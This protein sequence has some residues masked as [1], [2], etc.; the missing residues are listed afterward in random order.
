MELWHKWCGSL[1]P[2]VWH[3][4]LG[5]FGQCFQIT[6]FESGA[7]TLPY[8]ILI[9]LG[10]WCNRMHTRGCDSKTRTTEIVCCCIL[11]LHSG[12][13]LFASN[14][15]GQYTMPCVAMVCS[16]YYCV[17][18]LTGAF[19]TWWFPRLWRHLRWLCL[20]VFVAYT[21]LLPSKIQYWLAI[22][23][24][25]PTQLPVL[26]LVSFAAVYL[27]LGILVID[28]ILEV[29]LQRALADP[30]PDPDGVAAAH[31][32]VHGAAASDATDAA[33]SSARAS[34]NLEDTCNLF[35][36]VLFL[37]IW[38]LLQWGH[39]RGRL[40]FEDL[41]KIS[42]L[43]NP[44]FISHQFA[45]AWNQAVNR[46]PSQR[47]SLL[48]VLY[49]LYW[50]SFWL[51]G[52]LMFISSAALVC[53]PIFVRLLLEYADSGSEDGPLYGYT[54]AFGLAAVS[55]LKQ[56]TE[57]QFWYVGVRCTVHVQTA[58]MSYTYYKT[59]NLSAASRKKY[60]PG[61]LSNLMT[62]DAQRV[63]TTYAVPYFH[64][65]GW[66]ALGV[67]GFALY[68]L[69]KM[70]GSAS[71][72]GFGVMVLCLAVGALAA[73]RSL[74]YARTVQSQR[75]ARGAFLFRVLSNIKSIK[76]DLL[77]RQ[78]IAAVDAL[79]GTETYALLQKLGLWGL[80]GC[81]TD[82]SLILAP[83]SCLTA[84]CFL[85]HQHLTTSTVFTALT[86]FN[87]IRTPLYCFP[88]FCSAMVDCRVSFRRLEDLFF[89]SEVDA[90]AA[91]PRP[92]DPVPA[93]GELCGAVPRISITAASFG[94]DPATA[95]LHDISLQIHEGMFVAVVGPVGSGKTSLLSAI[96]R[97]LALL[98]GALTVRGSVAVVTQD[99]W[100]QNL[101][102]RDNVL[103]GRAFDAETYQTA[104]E[105]CKLGPDIAVLQ[106]LD[107]TEIG[108]DGVGLSGGQK[109][110]V[111]LARAIYSGA[112]I[113][114]LDDVLSAL[115]ASIGSQVFEGALVTALKGRTRIMA[116]QA[117][118]YLSSPHI[119]LIV[120]MGADGRVRAT[121]TYEELNNAGILGDTGWIAGAV[122]VREPLEPGSPQSGSARALWKT[123]RQEFRQDGGISL[124]VLRAYV[125]GI[126]WA[127]VGLVLVCYSLGPVFD[128]WSTFLLAA[129][130]QDPTGS[131]SVSE[132]RRYLLVCL[133][134]AA[135]N[136]LR[137]VLLLVSTTL[138][139]SALHHLMLRGVVFSPCRW[140][141][142]T[143]V[144]TVMNRLV[145]DQAA[146]DERVPS[147]ANQFLSY[148]LK[149]LLF[150]TI[151]TWATPYAVLL[152]LALLLPYVWLA[153]HYRW[154]ARD[155]RRLESVSRSPLLAHFAESIRG[156][157]VI[158]AYEAEG[159][160][161]SKNLRKIYCNTVAMMANAQAAQWI[162]VLSESLGCCV[163]LVVGVFAVHQHDQRA[164]SA[165]AL[166][167]LLN[168]A[169]QLPFAFGWVLKAYCA[170]EME[171]V[172]VERIQE[173]TELPP[174]YTQAPDC[175][176]RAASTPDEGLLDGAPF[177][178]ALPLIVNEVPCE[179]GALLAPTEDLNPPAPG[180][181]P[182]HGCV[183][184]VDVHLRYN[185]EVWALKGLSFR[186]PAGTKVAV[187]GR[188]G[189]GKSTLSATLLRL[190]PFTGSIL[191]DGVD[192][193]GLELHTL[194]S[195]VRFLPQDA[196]L[197]GTTLRAAIGGQDAAE[198]DIWCA[199]DTV[200][201]KTVVEQLPHK[202]DTLLSNSGRGNFSRGE[203]QLLCLAKLLCCRLSASTVLVCDECTSALDTRVDSTIHNVLLALPNTLLFI[204]HRLS[205][206]RKF[207][208]VLVVHDGRVQEFGPPEVL[209]NDPD[210]H[211]S[212]LVRSAAADCRA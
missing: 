120:V 156:A 96:V 8:I 186:L 130:T 127:L 209:M 102:L 190:Y 61:E 107:L 153:N 66:S 163:L 47:P 128:G 44:D 135:F 33:A 117:L 172:A 16:G 195:G 146:A 211:L 175:R 123:S 5:Q 165:K 126:P 36:R 176:A 46:H 52:F 174:E 14:R 205:H 62:V 60:S 100:I 65:G 70:L 143:V 27:V 170:L 86:W 189:A 158:R 142:H 45:M 103:F 51:S 162:T 149:L 77:E 24:A 48:M 11:A 204:C 208:A 203:L 177:F 90:E 152:A 206:I 59:L 81:L 138:A 173:Y 74:P 180:A 193:Q 184:F 114:I 28:I 111:S 118:H 212:A 22:L 15:D 140:F 87:T 72:I 79:R 30:D 181:W 17:L 88:N 57:H 125:H 151:M 116:T 31:P 210:S 68:E 134:Q 188:T 80:C 71:F 187:V 63:M 178:G 7:L 179:S 112:D 38:P 160:F 93:T 167:V 106:Y 41:P 35:G 171:L 95:V 194:R 191:I 110:R 39:H 159:R 26:R 12:S 137:V 132:L 183:E 1:D 131:G 56:L 97:D 29:L 119:N 133:S 58:L 154:A 124:R 139:S 148:F 207:G 34:D 196:G 25:H 49:K 75:D 113:I 105:A 157:R 144:G 164:L 13:I 150:L 141:D 199:L 198:S 92:Y 104:I 19:L 69:Y 101:S 50:R 9:L 108:E 54:L 155:L 18:W 197:F 109:Q 200:A 166:G 89:C 122:G 20:V 55:M 84:F 2:A 42:R 115:D 91:P 168:Y 147:A 76:C 4:H 82:V 185:A 99:P 169:I 83:V 136:L 129:W 64:W 40:E 23:N 78:V 6:V 32:T 3:G 21:C 182:S 161:N 201:M 192:I 94:W 73:N 202:L 37:Y 10:S 98:K 53:T 67:I 85:E 43:D 145:A 121:G